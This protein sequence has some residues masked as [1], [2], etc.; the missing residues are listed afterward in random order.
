MEQPLYF[1]IGDKV[2]LKAYKDEPKRPVGIITKF[3]G[4]A[5]VAIIDWQGTDWFEREDGSIS[6]IGDAWE[7]YGL[8]LLEGVEQ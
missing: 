5:T 1:N 8:W 3:K 2:T 7:I 6:H 4:F